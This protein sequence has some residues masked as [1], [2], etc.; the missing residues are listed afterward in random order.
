MGKK[1]KKAKGKAP[2]RRKRSRTRDLGAKRAGAVKGGIAWGGPT[3][4]ASKVD[5]KLT[6]TAILRNPS[7]K[8]V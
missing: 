4:T 5:H 6:D 8:S 3:L 7:S 2:A 1:K